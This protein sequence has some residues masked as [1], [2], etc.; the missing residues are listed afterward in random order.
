MTPDVAAIILAAGQASRWRAAGG[1]G[2]T[3]LVAEYKGAPVVR[4]AAEAALASGARPVIAVLGHEADAVRAALAGL[5]LRLVIARD[6]AEGLSASLRAG[7]AEV[8]AHCEG[9][10]VLLGDMPDVSAGL[11][12]R[13]IGALADDRGLDAVVP[14]VDGERGNP[15]LLTRSIFARVAALSG[16]QGARKLL[17]VDGIRVAE[18]AADAGARLDIDAPAA[19]AAAMQERSES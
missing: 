5:D 14:L 12:D 15:V 9:A 4:R 18:V 8:P 11:I 2:P 7:L 10:L 13:M 19:L 6:H 3:K 16:D 17:T 1:Q